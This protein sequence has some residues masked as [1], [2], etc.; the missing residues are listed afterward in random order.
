[1]LAAS[2]GEPFDSPHHLFEPK[3][4]GVRALGFRRDGRVWLQSRRGF[5][6]SHAFPEVVQALAQ[7]PGPGRAIVDGELV[8]PGPDGRPH[9]AA[10]LARSRIRRPAAALQAAREWPAMFV[11]FDLLYWADRDLRE[12]PLLARRAALARWASQWST[13]LP[14]ALSPAVGG[15]GR[16]LFEAVRRL[17]LEGM[18]AKHRESRYR[19]GRSRAWLKV[20]AFQEELAVVAG[21]VPEGAE[22]VRSLAVALPPLEAR[23]SGPGRADRGA[24]QG[25]DRGAGNPGAAL[26]LAGLVGTGLPNVE[27]MRLRRRLELLR[28]I[29]PAPQ[30][31]AGAARAREH[32]ELREVVWVRPVLFCRIRYLERT[33]DGWLRHASYRGLVDP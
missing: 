15:R 24:D 1:M 25:D 14:L 10:A 12:Q 11:L 17:G 32:P 7:L 23:A 31:A 4:D 20:K 5:E 29:R 13:E 18:V 26:V 3:W 28:L 21:F 8:T 27:R 33:A 6:L 30:V 2:A 19:A 9:F 16:E 22:S